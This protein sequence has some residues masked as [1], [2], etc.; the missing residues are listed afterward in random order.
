M[1]IRRFLAPTMREALAAVRDELGA[2]AVILSNR[3][4]AEGI[5]VVSAADYDPTLVAGMSGTRPVT[6]DAPP[7]PA[8]EET[9]TSPARRFDSI[10]ARV[11]GARRPPAPVETADAGQ[12]DRPRQ[13][14]PSA[15]STPRVV[16]SQ[17]REIVAMRHEV[18]ALRR[19]LEYQLARLSWDDLARREPFRAKVL[20]DLSSLDLAPDLARSLVNAMPKVTNP[21]DASRVALALLMRHLPVVDRELPGPGGCFALMGPTGIGK[22]TTVAKLAAQFAQAHGPAAVG[23]ISTD[24]YRIGAREQLAAFGRML[25]AAMKVATTPAELAAAR[26]AFS[27]RQLVLIDTAG[28]GPQDL[29]LREQA[30]LIGSQGGAVTPLLVLPANADLATLEDIVRAHQP[31]GP[32]ACV[33]TKLDETASLGAVMSTVIRASLPM[34]WLCDGQRVP[35][36]L[37]AAGP[38]RIWLIRRAVKLRARTGRVADPQYLAD[39]FGGG[40]AH[41]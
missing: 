21:E 33:L 31:V 8:D 1:K 40:L 5:E 38:R 24:R 39:Q 12:P 17:D 41:G 4:T 19:M 32:A 6:A 13:A 35:D 37:H 30:A 14:A 15:A 18:E 22:T 23:L 27:A 10:L 34:A 11:S 9:P 7:L 36:D 26:Q 25:G 20:R 2:D 16:W 3:R 29:R 28:V